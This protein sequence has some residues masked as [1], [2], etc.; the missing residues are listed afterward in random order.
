MTRK[1]IYTD[2]TECQNIFE[3]LKGTDYE[4]HKPHKGM[5]GKQ[6]KVP[7]GQAS[8]TL[9]ESIHYN[10]KVSGGSPPNYVMC[11]R[12]KAITKKVNE[13]LKTNFNTVLMNV[14]ENGEDHIS[15][16]KDKEDNWVEGTGFATLNFGCERDFLIE[17]ND[18]K[19]VQS[20]LHKNGMVLYLP[21]PMNHHY[22]H[23]VP[24]R[25]KVK[26]C[27]ISLTFREIEKQ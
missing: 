22:Q 5:H 14:Y 23:S 12:L 25:K 17:K 7:R 8:F 2:M 1:Q 3:M 15:Y 27:R 20:F 10:Y 24:K 9:D 11:D 16:H 19:E 4:H 21:H 13:E 26:G 18:T 6:V